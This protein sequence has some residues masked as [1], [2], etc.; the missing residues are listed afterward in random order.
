VRADPHHL[1]KSSRLKIEAS[2]M[3]VYDLWLDNV[4]IVGNAIVCHGIS[5]MI[6]RTSGQFGNESAMSS[7]ISIRR[8]GPRRSESA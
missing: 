5:G 2:F 4:R 7:G 3:L 1:L 6:L 8:D